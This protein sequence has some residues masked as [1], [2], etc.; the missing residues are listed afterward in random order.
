MFAKGL[1]MKYHLQLTGL[2]ALTLLLGACASS[3]NRVT[4]QDSLKISKGQ[5]LNDLQR[6]LN[7]GALTPDEYEALRKV[8]MRR[9]Q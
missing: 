3:S 8:I 2:V 6:A 7:A 4:V 9:P 1:Q 5:E